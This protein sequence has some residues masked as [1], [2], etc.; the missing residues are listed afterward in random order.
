MIVII[1]INY[2]NGNEI[3]VKSLG[4]FFNI[5]NFNIQLLFH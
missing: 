2:N 1:S 4:V 3:V 5:M